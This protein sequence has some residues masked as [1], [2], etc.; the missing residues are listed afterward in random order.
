[1]QTHKFKAH[2]WIKGLA[3]A[4]V[5]FSAV[6]C[7]PSA[8][9]SAQ[10]GSQGANIAEFAPG[11]Q[12]ISVPRYDNKNIDV[13]GDGDREHLSGY[14]DVNNPAVDLRSFAHPGGGSDMTQGL[15]PHTF[16]A[17]RISDLAHSVNG[18]A[19]ARSLIVGQTAIIGLNLNRSV[20]KPQ[21]SD[22]V[23][24]VR[25]RVLVQAPEFTRVHITTD[26][27]LVRK[28]QNISDQIRAGHSLTMFNDD[29]MSLT[30]Q[31]PAIGPSSMPVVPAR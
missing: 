8:N 21:V 27:A 9:R 7:T 24:Y 15:H 25:Q 14:N 11:G 28:I 13:D 3:V 20:K 1:M 18:V 19:N 30:H 16:T 6:G 22:L 29:I 17:D 10:Q 2:K 12:H 26:K 23:H 4:L 31:I 5:L